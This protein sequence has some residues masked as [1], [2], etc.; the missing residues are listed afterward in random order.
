MANVKPISDPCVNICRMDHDGKFC[1]GC[2]R[3]PL[4]IGSWARM[5]EQQKADV[6]ALI[7]QRVAPLS[8][9]NP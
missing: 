6:A 7:Q 2:K 3:T 8:V 4:E 9:P 5:T 1:Q